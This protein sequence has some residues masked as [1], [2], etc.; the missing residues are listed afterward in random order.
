MLSSNPLIVIH[1]R[2]R[3]LTMT[4]TFLSYKTITERFG[5]RF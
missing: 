4:G 1:P 3:R 2:P 5:H